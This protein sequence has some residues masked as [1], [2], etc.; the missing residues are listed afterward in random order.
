[1][2]L[3]KRAK[4]ILF[5]TSLVLS[6]FACAVSS[7]LAWVV[8]SNN[9][10]M[11]DTAGYTNGA[12]FARGKGT[13]DEPYILNAPIHLYNLSWL[14]YLGKF[15]DKVYYFE[16][17]SDIDSSGTEYE[18]IPPIG[19]EDHPFVGNFD[20][21]GHTIS[22]LKTCNKLGLGEDEIL[23]KPSLVDASGFS[24]DTMGVFGVVGT[25]EG[26]VPA[27]Q[28]GSIVENFNIK[29]YTVAS[30]NSDVLVGVVAG[31][32]DGELSNVKV[33]NE[34]KG[35]TFNIANV[36]S[37]GSGYTNLT[38]YGLVGYTTNVTSFNEEGITIYNPYISEGDSSSGSTGSDTLWG[39]SATARNLYSKLTT[40]A[41][42]S[43]NQEALKWQNNLKKKTAYYDS[44]GNVL[45]GTEENEYYTDEELSVGAS[46]WGNSSLE[47]KAVVGSSGEYLTGSI[48]RPAE[49]GWKDVRFTIGGAGGGSGD[50]SGGGTGGGESGETGQDAIDPSDPYVAPTT[51]PSIT[52]QYLQLNQWN[53]NVSVIDDESNASAFDRD[54]GYY[55][56]HTSEAGN[57]FR[58]GF[59]NQD[60]LQEGKEVPVSTNSMLRIAQDRGRYIRM[61]N[62]SDPGNGE[63]SYLRINAQNKLVV[64]LEPSKANVAYINGVL[65]VDPTKKANSRIAEPTAINPIGVNFAN[66]VR[67]SVSFD[68]PIRK[69]STVAVARYYKA[70][71]SPWNNPPKVVDN[72]AIASVAG[73][74]S[75][76][77]VYFIHGTTETLYP[78]YYNA[79]GE[80]E[81]PR[82]G[83]NSSAFK[84]KAIDDGTLMLYQDDSPYKN[85]NNQNGYMS[86][87]GTTFYTTYDSTKAN[88][89][90]N[91]NRIKAVV[92]V[93][94]GD[95]GDDAWVQKTYSK[96]HDETLGET[97]L[98]LTTYES[99]DIP[100]EDV[101]FWSENSITPSA[102]Y[103]TPNNSGYVVGGTKG[104]TYDETADSFTYE[105]SYDFETFSNS[106]TPF[107]ATSNFPIVT[108]TATTNGYE[109]VSQGGSASLLGSHITSNTVNDPNDL[110]F[111]RFDNSRTALNGQSTHFMRFSGD[112]VSKDNYIT[113]DSVLFNKHIYS[114]YELPEST[115]VFEAKERAIFN[116]FASSYAGGELCTGFASFYQIF[117]GNITRGEGESAVQ[118]TNGLSDIRRISK[119]YKS[120]AD[121]SMIYEYFE[122]EGYWKYDSS[123]NGYTQ[124]ASLEDGYSL[125][126]DMAWME[127]PG[128]STNH[129]ACYYFEWPVSPGEY[130]IGGTPVSEEST[131]SLGYICSVG[132]GAPAALTLGTEIY[133]KYV[134]TTKL[135][136][137]LSGI[138]FVEDLETTPKEEDSLAFS[139]ESGYSG[140]FKITSGGDG[141]VILNDY[142]SASMV[143]LYKKYSTIVKKSAADP[144]IEALPTSSTTKT[145]ER[146][147]NISTSANGN[148]I[149]R[150][151]T[152]TII[153]G[154]VPVITGSSLLSPYTSHIDDNTP[155]FQFY[156]I[157]SDSNTITMSI[158]VVT[159]TIPEGYEVDKVTVNISCL[160]DIEVT[161][162]RID[163][164][165]FDIYLNGRKIDTVQLP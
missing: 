44:D 71:A 68:E 18:K 89:T 133:E 118:V 125:V 105:S 99:D 72:Q 121:E 86:C 134:Q 165:T 87:D 76:G 31:K 103:P 151:V 28:D 41:N 152:S 63:G 15:D 50:D 117:R 156:F 64:T 57:T 5:A 91:G 80:K 8:S 112:N 36:T 116:M 79:P 146:L 110:G 111:E 157:H 98:P 135:Y 1:M 40:I 53:G 115:I 16:M 149:T 93:E 96:T 14:Q 81:T 11:A 3:S 69:A 139:I 102:N 88:V 84:F 54:E 136:S 141:T 70:D 144:P 66:E 22:G 101:T 62:P 106:Q 13:F 127:S 29:N 122:F 82:S 108:R 130:A 9:I 34:D 73:K 77:F 124:M 60:F 109:F 23:R 38:Q 4:N 104:Y 47:G 27:G 160:D 138:Y 150:V 56:S 42:D 61:A 97:Y 24:V 142:D 100:A 159:K 52:Y 155:V 94:P 39:A 49:K 48:D 33:S 19:T 114:D 32:V 2:S 164:N 132:L 21:K 140:T 26:E 154:G 137:V 128:F 83:N 92:M 20:G 78:C 43:S 131:A 37:G 107:G 85:S 90:L 59:W 25:Y 7:T 6:S 10:S 58:F 123:S 120:D 51:D 129:N 67:A 126:F 145:V 148:T 113:A 161:F 153:D 162:V 119:I 74:D 35:I 163:E 147:T 12:Y 30:Q 46:Q 143:L 75:K 158:G 65:R 17:E 55:L 95:L 45:D